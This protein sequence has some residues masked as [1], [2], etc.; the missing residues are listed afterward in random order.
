[1]RRALLLFASVTAFGMPAAAVHAQAAPIAL[2]A[3]SDSYAAL[4][5]EAAAKT[6]VSAKETNFS[7]SR[8]LIVISRSFCRLRP[9]GTA[10]GIFTTKE[11]D[12]NRRYNNQEDDRTDEHPTDDDCCERPLHLAADAGR[13]RRGQK[14]DTSRQ[15]SHQHRAH[16][17]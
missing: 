13:D 16:A 5:A 4:V 3:S 17:L 12:L 14:P 11:H 1:M 6:S 8:L 15:R 2:Q 9:L 10:G 7:F